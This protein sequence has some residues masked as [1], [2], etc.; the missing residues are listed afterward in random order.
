MTE[1][2]MTEQLR[3]C[4]FC[5]E[6]ATID[7]TE[8]GLYI[9]CT[10]CLCQIGSYAAASRAQM[11]ADWNTRATQ[12]LPTPTP[13]WAPLADLPPG[14]IFATQDGILAVKTT[15]AVYDGNDES[16]KCECILLLTGEYAHFADGDRTL[17]CALEVQRPQPAQGTPTP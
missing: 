8:H 1:Q 7:E 16:G 14:F 2:P 9:L 17:V 5:G 6:D 15:Y 10:E 12:P 11:V 3:E 4:P 13:T